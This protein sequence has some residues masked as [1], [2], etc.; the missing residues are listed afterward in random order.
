MWEVA[1]V[2]SGFLWKIFVGILVVMSPLIGWPYSGVCGDKPAFKY[3]WMGTD[4]WAAEHG[5][6]VNIPK[7][8]QKKGEVYYQIW[9]G[10]HTLGRLLP[11]EKYFKTHPEY[12]ALHNDKRIAAQLCLSN[13][14]VRRIV[15]DN[16]IAVI[17]QNPDLD[18][19]TLGPQDNRLFCQCDRCRALDE[20]NPAPDQVYSKR[21]FHFYKAVSERVHKAFPNI[22]IRFGCYDT[23]AAPPKDQNLTLPPNTYPLICHFQKYCNNYPIS[24]PTSRPNA[25][26]REI[27]AG[28]Q[29]L[30]SKLFVYEYYYKVNWLGLPWPLVHSIRK[31]IPWYRDNG[32]VG[33]YSQYNP[34]AA[35]SLL[36]YH[37]AAA[38]MVAEDADV[39]KLVE[40]FCKEMFGPAWEE[41]RKY[42]RVLE[43]AMIDAGVCIPG[44]GFAFPHAPKV[45]TEKVLTKCSDLVEAAKAKVVGTPYEEN[46]R[47]FSALMDYTKRCVAF[48]RLAV[49]GLGDGRLGVEEDRRQRTEDGRQRTEDGGW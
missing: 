18:I 38:L 46:V 14:D 43:N 12:F 21:M 48:L 39:D 9:G 5:C 6:N 27:I 49:A 17:R 8:Y 13:P 30:A 37:V 25:R 4:K 10:Y 42:Y 41:M 35:G 31:D 44:W 26:F 11:P 16:L 20:K 7:E 45:F 28:W 34:N 23:Y 33:F 24:D 19:V 29:K 40:G 2:K 1:P 47:K 22:I 36:N 15:A 32:V 3:R